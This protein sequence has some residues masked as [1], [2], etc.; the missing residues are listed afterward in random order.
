MRFFLC[1]HNFLITCCNWFCATWFLAPLLMTSNASSAPCWKYLL[2]LWHGSTLFL[3]WSF[4]VCAVRRKRADIL[5]GHCL[6]QVACSGLRRCVQSQIRSPTWF[7]WAWPWLFVC[8][9]SWMKPRSVFK[10]VFECSNL[11]TSRHGLAKLGETKPTE[12]KGFQNDIMSQYLCFSSVAYT[13]LHNLR[14]IAC[15]CPPVP[16]DDVE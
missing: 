5:S 13:S 3:Q 14:L 8:T 6:V 11:S 9:I 16:Q 1:L 15:R 2:Q 10:F 12:T 4:V 7:T